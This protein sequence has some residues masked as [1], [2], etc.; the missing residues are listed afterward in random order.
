MSASIDM[1]AMREMDV[2]GR[3]G[4]RQSTRSMNVSKGSRRLVVSSFNRKPEACATAGDAH[5]SGLRLN[6]HADISNRPRYKPG[7]SHVN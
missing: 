6:E 4:G 2:A 5:A 1:A 7:I 3:L